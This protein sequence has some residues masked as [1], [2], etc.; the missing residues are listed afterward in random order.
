MVN[1]LVPL[2]AVTTCSLTEREA[3]FSA[4]LVSGSSS[5]TAS[6]VLVDDV[7]TDTLSSLMRS[8]ST[9]NCFFQ[10]YITTLVTKATNL[11][12]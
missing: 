5:R 4:P 11:H 8:N 12:T 10:K 2:F 6:Q 3:S 9:T 1:T 7:A